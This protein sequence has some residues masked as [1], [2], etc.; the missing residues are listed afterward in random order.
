MS[1]KEA[2]DS[3]LC[4]PTSKPQLERNLRA[5]SVSPGVERTTDKLADQEHMTS[6]SSGS[7]PDSDDLDLRPPGQS[8]GKT[9]YP[10]W[11]VCKLS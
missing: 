7:A 11:R 9:W 4:W 5:P 2:Q 6:G 10:C 8:L 3:G 1:G